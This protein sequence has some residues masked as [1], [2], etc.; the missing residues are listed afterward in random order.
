MLR[1]GKTSSLEAEVWYFPDEGDEVTSPF[2][3]GPVNSKA[4]TLKSKYFFRPA[5][6]HG[7]QAW[8]VV[9]PEPCLW[10]I[11]T[12]A[13]YAL[14]GQAPLIGLRDLR[15]QG[16]NFYQEDRR[17]VIR[18]ARGSY[19]ND[20]DLFANGMI[21]IH[22]NGDLA[23]I[24]ANSYVGLP[25][26]IWPDGS[27]LIDIE[28]LSC[29]AAVLML[30]LPSNSS[31][32]I[33]AQAHSHL[34][35]GSEILAGESIPSW[36]KFA[37][38]SEDLIRDG[39]QPDRRLPVVVTRKYNVDKHSGDEVRAECDIFQASLKNGAEFAGLWLMCELYK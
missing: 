7:Q 18:A 5:E 4:K 38:V 30:I 31:R 26:I 25:S 13:V 34:L 23:Y 15:V 6:L 12:P 1:Q 36:S 28:R 20:K 16:T 32:D 10:S 27:P 33:V 19:S 21:P 22:R 35:L 24:D 17:W 3:E 37:V 9:I 11:L 39:W 2:L 8:K 14:N 29:S